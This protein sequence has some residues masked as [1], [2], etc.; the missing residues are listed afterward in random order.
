MRPSGTVEFEGRRI[1]AMT[2]GVMLEAGVWVRCV[3][4]K[5]GRVIVRQI[6]SPADIA[7]I[8]P[9]ENEARKDDV[10]GIHRGSPPANP[11]SSPLEP[12]KPVDDLDDLDL[13]LD[14]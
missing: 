10:S 8:V 12:K 11:S 6:E 1:D 9:D 2:E 4:V 7:D 5:G 3:E 13:G 14:K